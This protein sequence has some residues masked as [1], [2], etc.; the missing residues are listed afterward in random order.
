MGSMVALVGTVLDDELDRI[1]DI[2]MSEDRRNFDTPGEQISPN[3]SVLEA[4]E[5]TKEYITIHKLRP[6]SQD[7]RTW[8]PDRRKAAAAG[9]L[10]VEQQ[11]A[12]AITQATVGGDIADVE[13][14]AG[15]A[16]FQGSGRAPDPIQARIRI[17][18]R[19]VFEGVRK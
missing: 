5:A 1:V 12:F 18:A 11:E 6:D 3:Q 4:I 2:F 15:F 17:A 14:A 9:G 19:G 8:I 7:A 16:Q 10:S 13:E